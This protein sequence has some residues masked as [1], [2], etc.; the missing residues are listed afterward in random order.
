MSDDLGFIDAGVLLPSNLRDTTDL[1]Q[2]TQE[3]RLGSTGSGPFQWVFGGFYSKVDRKY[4]QRLPTP[5]YDSFD[6]PFL[7]SLCFRPVNPACRAPGVPLQSSDLAN[8]FPANSPYNADL[9]YDIKQK[10]VFGEVSY[11]F[12]LLELTAGARY[13]D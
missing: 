6:D 4:A 9:P 2:L 10:A 7:A 12:G 8:G 1:K 13:F 11:D 3:L 5:G